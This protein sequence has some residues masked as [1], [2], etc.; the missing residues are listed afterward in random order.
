MVKCDGRMALP[1]QSN[2]LFGNVDSFDLKSVFDQEIE[3]TPAA[4]AADVQSIVAALSELD[5]TFELRN[6]VRLKVR[7]LP[8]MGNRVV[9]AANFVWFH[10]MFAV[11]CLTFRRFPET[12]SGESASSDHSCQH[13]NAD[14]R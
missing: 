4:S 8:N 7:L 2:H 6:S 13:D 10:L 12:A 1:G 14:E 11:I 5:C 3:K 9:T